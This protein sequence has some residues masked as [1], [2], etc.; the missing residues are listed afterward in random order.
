MDSGSPNKCLI[1]DSNE[2][3]NEDNNRL[4]QAPDDVEATME[5]QQPVI[6]YEHITV[7]EV[8]VEDAEVAVL[9]PND[10]GVSDML[11]QI[12]QAPYNVI[13]WPSVVIL[14]GLAIASVPKYFDHDYTQ[15]LAI[16]FVLLVY[17]CLLLTTSPYKDIIMYRLEM[18]LTCMLL[19]LGVMGI[20][21]TTYLSS[22]DD[23]IREL[24]KQLNIVKFIILLLP[25]P[26]LVLFT[27]SDKYQTK[28]PDEEVDNELDDINEFQ[29]RNADEEIDNELNEINE[30]LTRNADEVVDNELNDYPN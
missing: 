16:L 4:A 22:N 23:N 18:S 28:I 1:E 26:L 30:F 3:N 9:E 5:Q 12:V 2:G 14:R 21:N 24:L 19:F 8:D 7:K 25:L 29:P 20:V 11:F 27:I 6:E 10:E 13:Y 15:I 17:L